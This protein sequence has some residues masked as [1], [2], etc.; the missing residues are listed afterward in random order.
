M[1]HYFVTGIFEVDG[2]DGSLLNNSFKIKQVIEIEYVYNIIL[3]IGR[4]I[5]SIA[6]TKA[7][8]EYG[9][10]ICVVQ[11]SDIVIKRYYKSKKGGEKNSDKNK[12]G[13]Q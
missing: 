5:H 11:I 1:P 7:E 10:R 2:P 3:L 13:G 4:M 12:S 8:L 9:K 6:N